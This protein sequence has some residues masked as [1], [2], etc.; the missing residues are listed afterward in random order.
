MLYERQSSKMNY[1]IKWH[2]MPAGERLIHLPGYYP[3][4]IAAPWVKF[5]E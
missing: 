1:S 3:R 4:S 2:K 5:F